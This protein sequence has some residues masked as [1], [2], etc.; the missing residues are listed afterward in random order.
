[1]QGWFKHSKINI[2]HHI[3]KLKKEKK[4]IILINIEK[5]FEEINCPFLIKI[6][7][8]PGVERYFFNLR[9][10][11]YRKP[12]ADIILNVETLKAVVVFCQLRIK[13]EIYTSLLIFK[14]LS[15]QEVLA[16]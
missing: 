13:V 3:H 8:K 2:N 4:M 15:E 6:F 5:A 7:N 12:T 16:K 10:V 14:I 1:M 11:I 9:K